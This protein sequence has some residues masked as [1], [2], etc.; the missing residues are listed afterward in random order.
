M[1]E[2]KLQAKIVYYA[3]KH[4]IVGYK[5][6]AKGTVGFPD[7]YLAGHGHHELFEIKNPGKTGRLRPGQVR[8]IAELREAGVTVRVIDDYD[9]ARDIIDEWGAK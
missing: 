8:R 3:K 5:V 7:L 1:L 9:Q 2:S 6:E 4:G